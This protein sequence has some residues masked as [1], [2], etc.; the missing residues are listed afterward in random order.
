MA[1]E[2]PG[3]AFLQ[4]QSRMHQNLDAPQCGTRGSGPPTRTSMMFQHAPSDEDND[5]AGSE[6]ETLS[7][8]EPE[9]VWKMKFQMIE[10][11]NKY[12]DQKLLN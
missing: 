11:P 6:G 9:D 3:T 7:V 2:G 5:I 12:L 8:E 1:S 10:N 4:W